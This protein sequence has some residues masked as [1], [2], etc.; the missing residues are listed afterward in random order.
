MTHSP[1]ARMLAA[2]AFATS[3]FFSHDALAQCANGITGHYNWWSGNTYHNTGSNYGSDWR[4]RPGIDKPGYMVYGPYDTR[5]G[6]GEH[7]AAY[8]LQVDDNT[9]S[10]DEII[11]SLKV[12]TRLGKRILAQRDLTRR[13]FL[14]PN[15]WQFFTVHFDNPCFEQLETTIYW[16]GNAQFVFGQVAIDKQ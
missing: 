9:T 14:T 10:P 16:Y 6:R 7:T 11:A 5:F 3:A 8:Y 13:D 2:L 1:I 12:Y 4:V 15:A